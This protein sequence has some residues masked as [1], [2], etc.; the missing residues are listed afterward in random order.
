MCIQKIQKLAPYRCQTQGTADF[1]VSIFAD[2]LAPDEWERASRVFQK[3]HLLSHKMGVIDE[4]YVQKAQ[5]SR[6][7]SRS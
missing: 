1:S 2:S 7:R 3:R 6:R 4:E 5:R